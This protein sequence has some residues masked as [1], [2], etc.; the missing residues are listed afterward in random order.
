MIAVMAI[1]VAAIILSSVYLFKLVTG[2][3]V[4]TI[5]G[6]DDLS[7]EYTASMERGY[8]WHVEDKGVKNAM[9][10]SKWAKTSVPISVNFDE[11][12]AHAHGFV[13]WLN[14][15]RTANGI[16]NIQFK[17][18]CDALVLMDFA[19]HGG[20]SFESNMSDGLSASQMAFVKDNLDFFWFRYHDS[21]SYIP[22]TLPP[23]PGRSQ[24]VFDS[25]AF[26]QKQSEKE[27]KYFKR[28]LVEDFAYFRST[29]LRGPDNGLT[30]LGTCDQRSNWGSFC[31]TSV[32]NTKEAAAA[33]TA[34]KSKKKKKNTKKAKVGG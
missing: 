25:E 18:L 20:P 12:I 6:D 5:L 13:Q 30:S 32:N 26:Q 3:S 2:G 11:K 21:N 7:E 10:W 23:P 14:G 33:K 9:P 22:I 19:E 31:P 34:K 29:Q 15:D 28:N 24:E 27:D 17:N 1:T 8:N 16:F 4:G